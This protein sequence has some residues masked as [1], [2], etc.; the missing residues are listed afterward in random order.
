[1]E[2]DN[3]RQK[4]SLQD[5]LTGLVGVAKEQQSYCIY[6]SVTCGL[7]SPLHHANIMIA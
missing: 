7:L 4:H 1:M 2:C 3:S 5:P 6:G